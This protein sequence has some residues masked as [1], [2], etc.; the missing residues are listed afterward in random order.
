M[1]NE[2]IDKSKKIFDQYEIYSITSENHPI[3]FESNKSM[4][5]KLVGQTCCFWLVT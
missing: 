4:E 2:V 1:I 3:S 5:T